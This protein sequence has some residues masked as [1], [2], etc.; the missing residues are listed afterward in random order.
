MNP[1]FPVLIGIA[2]G[3]FSAYRVVRGIV[4]VIRADRARRNGLETLVRD[5][6]SASRD[7]GITPAALDQAVSAALHEDL[8][9]TGAMLA[10]MSVAAVFA[11]RGLGYGEWAV[12]LYT[13]GLCGIVV[14]VALA[15][16]GGVLH[17]LTLP[18]S[19]PPRKDSRRI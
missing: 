18:L 1:V 2:L 12:G 15:L 7:P 11:G 9:L 8:T 14:G 5:P 16:L 4:Q 19:R 17:V 13:A 10:S 3:T 6:L